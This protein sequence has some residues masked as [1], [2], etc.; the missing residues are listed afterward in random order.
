MFIVAN[1]LAGLANVLDL[2]LQIYLWLVV[3][4]A[5]LSWVNPDPHNPIVR[6][7]H[8]VTDPVLYWVRRRIPI[9]FGGIDFSPML[10]ILALIFLR[11]FV[12][13]SLQELAQRLYY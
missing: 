5:V 9:S 4:R 1:F 8:R 7:L 12:V 2:V 10:V 3:A 11:S 6:F 13:Q